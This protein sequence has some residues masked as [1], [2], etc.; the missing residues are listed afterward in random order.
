[1]V[2]VKFEIVLQRHYFI[3]IST[4][5]A[6]VIQQYNLMVCLDFS[7]IG[8]DPKVSNLFAGIA[9]VCL[10]RMKERVFDSEGSL[11][12]DFVDYSVRKNIFSSH[13]SILS[14]K[15]VSDIKN[16]ASNIFFLKI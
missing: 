5:F 4:F 2:V 1:V 11:E 14:R 9:T 8:S 12:T 15:S 13:C 7:L 3:L 10:L 16:F 6:F